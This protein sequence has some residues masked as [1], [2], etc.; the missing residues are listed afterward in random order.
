MNLFLV[1]CVW[2]F[3]PQITA[4]VERIRIARRY[5]LS[6]K[7]YNWLIEKT[8]DNANDDD[9]S[10]W[11]NARHD[12]RKGS[13]VEEWSKG[14]PS[15]ELHQDTSHSVAI[16]R[17][18]VPTLSIWRLRQWDSLTRWYSSTKLHGIKHH[19]P[20]FLMSITVGIIWYVLL[21]KSVV[22]T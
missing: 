11:R 17:C 22:I 3:H 4:H 13:S 2:S 20:E 21:R 5:V 7:S 10:W 19:N 16:W 18:V 8:I 12:S 1:A 15:T 9:T 6:H 14:R